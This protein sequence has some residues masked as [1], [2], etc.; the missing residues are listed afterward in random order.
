V[1]NNDPPPTFTGKQEKKYFVLENYTH[2]SDI[3]PAEN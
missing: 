2:G 1:V 3:N